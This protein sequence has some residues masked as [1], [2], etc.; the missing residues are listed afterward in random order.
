[1]AIVIEDVQVESLA[2]Q[3]AAAEGVSVTEVLRES[4]R[5]LAGV[6]GLIPRKEPLRER[7]AA[8]AREIDNMPTRVPLDH[9]NDDEILGYN[10]HGT[11]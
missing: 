6:R 7:L 5:S 3:L 11:W 8:L 9:R 2:K 1:M 4:L 10:E